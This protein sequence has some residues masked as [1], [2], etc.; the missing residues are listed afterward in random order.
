[1]GRTTDE[2]RQAGRR[3]AHLT[4]AAPALVSTVSTATHLVAFELRPPRPRTSSCNAVSSSTTAAACFPS[5][6]AGLT[7]GGAWPPPPP[8]A[9]SLRGIQV[10]AS[11][12]EE[13]A[14]CHRLAGR[15]RAGPRPF[16]RRRQWTRRP[17]PPHAASPS[18]A[19]AP[20]LPPAAR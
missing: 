14:R 10:I 6:K 19:R 18:G 1:M 5:A 4:I 3:A 20:P 16:R 2:R 15:S 13:H 8:Q 17:P 7:G 9:P 11:R 12:A